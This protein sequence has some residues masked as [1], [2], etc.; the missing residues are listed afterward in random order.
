MEVKIFINFQ[1]QVLGFKMEGD[2]FG[3][4]YKNSR[5]SIEGFLEEECPGNYILPQYCR[6]IL[7]LERDKLCTCKMHSF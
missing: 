4:N 1:K 5:K 2:L 3:V 7:Y 6:T